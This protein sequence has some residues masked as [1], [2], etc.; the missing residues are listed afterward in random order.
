MKKKRIL[1]TS[2]LFLL[3]GSIFWHPFF[4]KPN[5]KTVLKS[6]AYAYLSNE[7][8]KY[9]EEVYEETG[10]IVLT[11]N[12]KEENV[13]YLNPQYIEYL[14]L[15]DE[16][17]EQV[18]E[19]PV[20]Y[21]IQFSVDKANGNYPTSYDLRNVGG[22]N[23][24][25]PLKDQ[26]SL[27]L[28]WDFTTIAQAE[29]YL[30]LKSGQGYSSSFPL[31]S[32]RQLDYATSS[33]GF[34]EYTN[35][36]GV[37]EL[38]SGGNFLTG[39][40]IMANGLGMVYE[41]KMPLNYNMA[42]K[43]LSAVLNYGNSQY[44]LNSSIY[45]P[46]ITSTTTTSDRND[47]IAAIKD[48]IMNYGGA[49]VGTQG[50]GYSCSS[51]NNGT[52]FIRVDDGC[53]ENAGHAMHVIGWDDNYS[54]SY[55]KTGSGH[56]NNTASCAS[57]NLVQGTGAWLLRNSWGNSYSYVYL[58]YDSLE[59]DFYSLTDLSSMANRTWDNNYHKAFDPYYVYLSSTDTQVFT[60]KISGD[61]KVEKVK[62]F[63]YGKGG[64]FNISVTSGDDTYR[65]ITSVTVP[66]PGYYTVDLSSYNII[67]KG[68]TI[69][70]TITSP[71]RV[72]LMKQS[73]SVF[74]SNVS[75]NSII[76]TPDN[77]RHFDE[78]S[79]GY[80]FRLYS[81][82]KNIPSN[83]NIQY[84]LWKGSENYSSYLSASNTVTAKNN[85]NSSISISASIPRGAYT[86]RLSYA[87]VSEDITLSIGDL[88]S[89]N[90]YYYANNGTTNSTTQ[91]VEA[92][93]AFTLNANS[94]TRTGYLFDKWNTEADGSGTNYQNSQA[95][96]GINQNLKLYAQWNPITYTVSY[97]ANG[98]V[99][100][101]S[102]QSFVYDVSKALNTNTFT[103]EGYRFASWN[104]K[105]DGSGKVYANEAV[106]SNLTSVNLKNIVLY[107]Q[108]VEDV[109]YVIQNYRVDEENHIIDLI[110]KETTPYYYKKNFILDTG[111][112]VSIDIG[113]KTY[114]Y[115]GSVV[116]IYNGDTMVAQYTNVV[117][118]DINEDGIINSADLLRMRQ[119]LL[120]NSLTMAPAKA[121]DINE[122]GILNSAD[123]LR[124]RQHLLGSKIIS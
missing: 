50:P 35:E 87:N 74:T 97:N 17:K 25:T 61:E 42:T 67:A 22:K 92:N 6:D 39:S 45:F 100:T 66:Y 40:S 5:I 33:N 16:E 29:S 11:E 28:C 80:S 110:G 70:V 32:T 52:T 77:D 2:F 41:S 112:S 36:D 26:K 3:I 24:V 106:V 4:Y 103:K 98:G 124:I 86:L 68:D 59:D 38:A 89:W 114:V 54:Y 64:T 51:S 34:N 69:K 47:I 102:S 107:A 46:R 121:A 104:T 117:Q 88:S 109:P 55:C 43:E 90:V 108:W 21:V 15:S 9:I 119:H 111:Y 7:A 118:G 83:S 99:G 82:T 8:K 37:R 30:L 56:S 1:I 60:K 79:S 115:T 93:T 95:M 81:D 12:N 44:E 85:V 49:Y 18:E 96:S 65:N 31:Y 57:S 76:Y 72:S 58:A 94:F 105:A 53:T 78:N 120:G 27:D 63:S 48:S 101:M 122:D 113:T 14:S 10:E 62:F 84:G 20:P 91:T 71:N 123:L 73:M 23:Y 75:T 116:K 13:P 19:I